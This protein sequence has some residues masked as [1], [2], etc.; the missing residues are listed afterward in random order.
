MGIRIIGRKASSEYLE[1]LTAEREAMAG[2]IR[3][4][5]NGKVKLDSVVAWNGTSAH[6]CDGS[7][8]E[9]AYI[10]YRKPTKK[11]VEE[12]RHAK[13]AG[14]SLKLMIGRVI[15][16][17]Y[18]GDDDDTLMLVTNGLR[19]PA[20]TDIP[21]RAMNVTRG[22]VLGI[23]I[24]QPL[25]I[26]VEDLKKLLTVEEAEALA[27]SELEEVP[28]DAPDMEL[29]APAVVP[30]I[31]AVPAVPVAQAPVNP[32]PGNV[33]VKVTLAKLAEAV[34]IPQPTGLTEADV[35]RICNEEL[36]NL[37]RELTKPQ[38]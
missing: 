31:P 32:A 7:T 34:G 30:V 24:D 23:A 2:A 28:F 16:I 6:K 3:V 18:T 12:A 26:S 19:A 21:F 4:L 1:Q 37:L 22:K 11:Q 10:A 9:V 13:A 33:P 20:G 15:D 36:V 35:R 5:D 14:V 29:A 27:A 25:G 38:A 17:K 8:I